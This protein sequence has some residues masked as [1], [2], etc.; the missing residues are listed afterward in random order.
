MELDT[1]TNWGQYSMFAPVKDSK[2]SIRTGKT[3]SLS[4]M[5]QR[6]HESTKREF[7]QDYKI[8]DSREPFAWLC[9]SLLNKVESIQP[10]T[11]YTKLSD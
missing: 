10:S 8:A 6:I 1:F 3:K 7:Q 2:N 5:Y 4:S 9:L 11:A